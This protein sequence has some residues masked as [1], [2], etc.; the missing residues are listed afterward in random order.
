MPTWCES[1]VRRPE[2]EIDGRPHAPKRSPKASCRSRSATWRTRSST[3]RC[4]AAT[5]SPRYTLC[6]FG[7]A[8][9]QHA[10]LV[11]DALAM[12]RVFIHPHAGVLSAYG[13]GLADQVAM[14]E[15]GGRGEARR[16]RVLAKSLA[17]AGG[18]ASG[19][20]VAQGVPPGRIATVATAHL[21]YEGTDTALAVPLGAD[22]GD[23][24]AVRGGVP[25]AVLLPHAGQGAGRRGGLGRG[26][27]RRRGDRRQTGR[28]N[29]A[30]RSPAETVRM[31]YR[32]RAGT[33]RRST[34]ARS[35]RA[36]PADR[37]PGD[38]RRGERHDGGRA[39]VARGGF[40]CSIT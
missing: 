18:E 8:A 23:D 3:S 28:E 37:R 16:S 22:R 21:K 25:Q 31:F 33:R 11:A 27:R 5:T 32:R 35:S 34:G 6:C 13:M 24:G 2:S 4:S 14:R 10:C 38:H 7:G 36:G 17:R 29:G 19:D 30:P 9:G 20:L 40:C 26:D 15:P 1:R 39:R 12:T